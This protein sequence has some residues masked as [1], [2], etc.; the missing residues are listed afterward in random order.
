MPN[1]FI[2]GAGSG[3]GADLAFAFAQ[4]KWNVAIHYNNSELNAANLCSELLD[5]AV[6]SAI[7]KADISDYYQLE[8][9]YYSALKHF[10]NFDVLINNAGIFPDK[11]YIDD[12]NPDFWDNVMNI[13][14]KSQVFLAKL[15]S[16]KSNQGHIV[17]IASLG[18]FEVWKERTAY[19]V[20]KAAV[21]QLT[22]SL[23]LDLTPRIAVNC[24][25]PGIIKSSRH[26]ND[27]VSIPKSRI[28]YGDYGS[29]DDFFAAVEFFATCPKF[30]TGQFLIVDGAYNLAR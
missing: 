25:A 19:N 9:A 14:L 4:K 30:I 7:F 22:K 21:V 1:V 8:H 5:L 26:K 12:L 27:N 24:V 18:G 6:D 28:P 20:S 13:N 16:Q 10:G 11:K 17:N 3:L 2:S 23:A 15:F 29:P